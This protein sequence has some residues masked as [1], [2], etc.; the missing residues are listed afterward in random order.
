M[1]TPRL[2]RLLIWAAFVF[3]QSFAAASDEITVPDVSG[4]NTPKAMKAAAGP[5]MVGVILAT[6]I[7][8][9]DGS[10]QLFAYQEP[11]ANT[12]APRGSTLKIYI[13]QSLATAVIPSPT[14]STSMPDLT[15][16]TLEQAVAQLPPNTQV[17]ADGVGEYP[18]TPEKALTIFSQTPAK[19]QPFAPVVTVKRYGSAKI[20]DAS[21]DPLAGRWVGLSI[22]KSDSSGKD[23]EVEML[24]RREGGRYVIYVI[25]N[26]FG[27]P[28]ETDGVKM[29]HT[30]GIRDITYQLDGDTLVG[31][32][33]YTNR[34]GEV[35][36]GKTTF[37]RK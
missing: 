30:F 34:R 27:Y 32:W 13:Y 29:W 17:L 20:Y 1:K 22:Y 6:K 31:E 25:G 15:G 3:S 26:E 5:D 7:T 9:P 36:T 21:T 37:R 2:L 24:I 33:R 35:H 28:L 16:L 8:P 18:P 11:P 12:K 4:F 14:P 19:G 23:L 10:T